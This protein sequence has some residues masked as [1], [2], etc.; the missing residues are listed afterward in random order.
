M[1]VYSL[2]VVETALLCAAC[3]AEGKEQHLDDL[4]KNPKTHH[5]LWC[6]GCG[7]SMFVTNDQLKRIQEVPPSEIKEPEQPPKEIETSPSTSSRP[8][9]ERKFK[10]RG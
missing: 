8:T 6:R 5:R 3:Q 9:S 2:T 7:S 10:I 1:T 4:T